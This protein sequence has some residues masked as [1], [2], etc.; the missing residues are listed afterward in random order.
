MP[1][2]RKKIKPSHGSVQVLSLMPGCSNTRTTMRATSI[3]TDSS[4]HLWAFRKR[5]GNTKARTDATATPWLCVLRPQVVTCRQ[6]P[7]ESGNTSTIPLHGKVL[8]FPRERA[9]LEGGNVQTQVWNEVTAA[10]RAAL[11]P[12]PILFSPQ[13]S[14]KWSSAVLTQHPFITANWEW[15]S[16]TLKRRTAKNFQWN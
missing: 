13:M 11:L 3:C 8:R 15:I 2:G 7:L 5:Q 1:T 4:D 9:L 16:V 12:K 14:V 6:N 10:W